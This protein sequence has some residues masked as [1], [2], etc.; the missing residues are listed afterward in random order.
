MSEE[1][2]TTS[3]NGTQHT[4]RSGSWTTHSLGSQYSP[5]PASVSFSSQQASFLQIDCSNVPHPP[6]IPY[7]LQGPLCPQIIIVLMHLYETFSWNLLFPLRR[8]KSVLKEKDKLFI[9]YLKVVWPIYDKKGVHGTKFSNDVKIKC[10]ENKI[11]EV[12][13]MSTW[14][15]V[16][17]FCPLNPLD[18][19][20]SAYYLKWSS[21]PHML[22]MTCVHPHKQKHTQTHT[23][24]KEIK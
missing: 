14:D 20:K 11:V 2:W 5:P 23:H 7:K 13:R 21:D 3:R 24:N 10:W 17:K 4:R 6:I 16:L 22:S 1:H 15:L 9:T 8:Q 18:E 12:M 19:K